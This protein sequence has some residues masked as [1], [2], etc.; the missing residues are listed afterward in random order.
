MLVQLFHCFSCSLPK[1]IDVSYIVT[2]FGKRL[3]LYFYKKYLLKLVV[4][5]SSEKVWSPNQEYLQILRPHL[6]P[7][8][9]ETLREGPSNL[10]FNKPSRWFSCTAC[11]R[12]ISLRIWK[13]GQDWVK[14]MEVW[15]SLCLLFMRPRLK[16]MSAWDSLIWWLQIAGSLAVVKRIPREHCAHILYLLNRHSPGDFILT[17]AW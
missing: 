7:T 16:L 17:P 12:T 11:L 5:Y 13:E 15:S 8:E 4:G 2:L 6:R 3:L 14:N 9:S 10:H 1:Y